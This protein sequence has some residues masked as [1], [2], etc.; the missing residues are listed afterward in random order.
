MFSSEEQF[1]YSSHCIL[2]VNR[3]EIALRIFRT[4]KSLG[5]RTVA[6]YT[7]SDAHA[8]H[9]LLAD[10]A[11][12]LSFTSESPT[13]ASEVSVYLSIEHIISIICEYNAGHSSNPITLVHPGYGFLS[14]NATFASRVASLTGATWV[15]PRPEVIAEMGLKHVARQVAIRA[16]LPVVPGSEGLL[17]PEDG[18]GVFDI[19]NCIGY[20]IILKA[21]AGGGGMGMAICYN[22]EQLAEELERTR[23]RAKILFGEEGVFLEKYFPAARHIEIQVLYLRHYGTGGFNLIF[24]LFVQVFGNGLGDVVHLA[25]RECSIQRR[26]QKIIEETPSPFLQANE[27]VLKH[28]LF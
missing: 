17:K 24:I 8:P 12:A 25:E 5:I 16:G 13:G 6:V 21:T 1:N 22:E 3:G 15:G 2:V 10:D 18:I 7:N 11:V 9:V 4:A 14:E 23:G 27:G 20:P 19:A 28:L 26:H